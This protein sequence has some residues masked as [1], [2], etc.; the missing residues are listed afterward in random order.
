MDVDETVEAGG[1]RLSEVRT[2]I[3]MG[4]AGIGAR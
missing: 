3:L 1:L 4:L 2:L